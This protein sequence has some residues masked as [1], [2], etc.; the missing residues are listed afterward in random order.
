MEG[1]I[2][3]KNNEFKNGKSKVNS[4]KKIFT[5]EGKNIL[6]YVQNMDDSGYK[7]VLITLVIGLIGGLIIGSL[8]CPPSTRYTMS[9]GEYGAESEM[10][11]EIDRLTEVVNEKTNEIDLLNSV[12]DYLEESGHLSTEIIDVDFE[13]EKLTIQIKN[14]LPN[15]VEIKS[16]GLIGNYAYTE[17][18]F[19]DVSIDAI[20]FVPA[21]GQASFVWNKSEANTIRLDSNSNTVVGGSDIPRE[22]VDYQISIEQDE[23]ILVRVECEDG[24]YYH[25]NFEI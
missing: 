18:W 4:I 16:I 6:N 15:Q 17:D 7:V 1:R 25:H 23:P 8:N 22:N 13:H 11:F 12:I 5:S 9:N 2:I 24:T 21:S 10:M 19:V 3:V 20:G 14:K